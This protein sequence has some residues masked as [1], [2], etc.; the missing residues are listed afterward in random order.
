[1]AVAKRGGRRITV[2]GVPLRWWYRLAYCG[3][4]TCPQDPPHVLISH[5]SREGAVVICHLET[6][7]AAV[8]PSWIAELVRHAIMRGWR[9]GVGSGTVHL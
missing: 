8:T 1:M 4:A 3:S 5:A 7:G 9:P 6:S 2:D